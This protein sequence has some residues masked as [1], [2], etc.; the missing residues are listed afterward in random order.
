[1]VG[2]ESRHAVEELEQLKS[3]WIGV[4]GRRRKSYTGRKES[5]YCAGIH[6]TMQTDWSHNRS[7]EGEAAE[8]GSQDRLFVGL[9]HCRQT[10]C[11]LK[12]S[13]V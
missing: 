3:T 8:V 5:K 2:T 11:R 12:A 4:Q 7:I 10:A 1:M 9:V 6:H 13:F